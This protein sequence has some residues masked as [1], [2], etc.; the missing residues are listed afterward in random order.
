[1]C[2]INI[3]RQRYL[4]LASRNLLLETL[5]CWHNHAYGYES[6]ADLLALAVMTVPLGMCVMSGVFTLVHDF[7]ALSSSSCH[8]LSSNISSCSSLNDHLQVSQIRTNISTNEK[9]SWMRRTWEKS[10]KTIQS[11]GKCN[12][13]NKAN[14][15]DWEKKSSK[16]RSLSCML[17]DEMPQSLEEHLI[18]HSFF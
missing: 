16:N 17:T 15:R 13:I 18:G 8:L 14:S 12:N 1:M 3:L 9:I 11:L 2:W 10:S 6:H 5:K 4:W 7:A